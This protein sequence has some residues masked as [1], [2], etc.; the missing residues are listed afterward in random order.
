[1]VK[2]TAIVDY[3]RPAMM[4]EEALHKLHL[5]TIDRQYDMAIEQTIEL[6][7]QSR[8]ILNALRHMQEKEG[9][10]K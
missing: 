1:M 7:V 4:A 9:A 3:A 6:I 8:L 10:W 5:A 2:V